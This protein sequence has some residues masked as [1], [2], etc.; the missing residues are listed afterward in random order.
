MDGRKAEAMSATRK[1]L[2]HYRVVLGRKTAEKLQLAV[3]VEDPE[4][5]E[6]WGTPRQGRPKYPSHS[7]LYFR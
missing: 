6:D 4:E 7:G 1:A 2:E 5:W 3:L